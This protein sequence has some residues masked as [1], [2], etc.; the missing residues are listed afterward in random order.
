MNQ[1]PSDGNENG[2]GDSE[3][4][5]QN[6]QNGVSPVSYESLT[7]ELTHR[8]ITSMGNLYPHGTARTA[9]PAADL[10]RRATVLLDVTSIISNRERGDY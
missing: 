7:K 1:T 8:L 5:N 4:Q 9:Q 6:Q 2:T 10:S 3:Q